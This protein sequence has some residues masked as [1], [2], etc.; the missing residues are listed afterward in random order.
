M[1]G[2]NARNDAVAALIAA[3]LIFIGTAGAETYEACP[4]STMVDN[5]W[6]NGNSC[7]GG[8]YAYGKLYFE[9]P[10]A[11]L[12]NATNEVTSAALV[13]SGVS[14]GTDIVFQIWNGYG[15]YAL[16]GGT[17]DFSGDYVYQLPYMPGRY[18]D[19]SMRIRLINTGDE[20]IR[21]DS[22]RALIEFES[23]LKTFTLTVTDCESGEH[24]EGI[25]VSD[26]GGYS[27]TTDHNGVAVFHIPKNDARQF[28]IGSDNYRTMYR[29]IYLTNDEDA[30]VCLYH[31]DRHSVDVSGLD[32]D[33]GIISFNIENTGNVDNDYI[34]YSIFV[35]NK[36]IFTG[37]LL[38]DAG[39]DEDVTGSY[40]FPAGRHKVRARA[41]AGDYADSQ[42]VTYCVEG[43]TDN[44]RC[45]AGNVVRETI[46]G[47]CVS[48]WSVVKHCTS[49]CS[50]GACLEDGGAT[51]FAPYEGS[52][53]AV[54]ISSFNYADMVPENRPLEIEAGLSNTGISAASAKVNL[55]ADGRY[56]G[57]KTVS[58]SG[59]GTGSA[60]FKIYLKKGEHN[61]NVRIYGCSGAGSSAGVTLRTAPAVLDDDEI[62]KSTGP[63]PETAEEIKRPDSIF[64]E[65]TPHEVHATES[66]AVSFM[67]S[68]FP[69]TEMYE[70][71]VTGI[72]QKR[73]DYPKTVDAASSND[74]YVHARPETAGN[75]TLKVRVWLSGNQSASRT[76]TVKISVVSVKAKPY[77]PD[78]MS[79]MASAG[80]APLLGLLIFGVLVLVVMLLVFA[81]QYMVEDYDYD[82]KLPGSYPTYSTDELKNAAVED[83]SY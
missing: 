69:P 33:S 51:V 28:E 59:E 65:I 34:S 41:Q 47:N 54:E 18:T 52:P 82:S 35:D 73:L 67:V 79:G 80:S 58:V 22:V 17:I 66:E 30:E 23:T 7:S 4:Y 64:L 21:I 8:V 62:F 27:E 2:L 13:V 20:V 56:M 63:V 19:G 15:W 77:V 60:S 71:Y 36:D 81:R 53:C 46:T 43:T 78:S 39:D 55:Y 29:N 32:V 11:P 70:V 48:Q 49:G 50:G 14:Q 6:W 40:N 37:S 25:R 76:E 74:F 61:V 12:E 31:I 72:D 57:S 68:I 44:Y 38:L 16:N 75:Y 5:G 3:L 83:F 26:S 45:S 1:S 10:D 42:T 9:W 24:L